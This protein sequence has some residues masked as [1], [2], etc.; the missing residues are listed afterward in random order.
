[1]R[2]TWRTAFGPAAIAAVNDFFEANKNDFPTNETRQVFAK[3]VVENLAFL[4]SNTESDEPSASP[5]FPLKR[6]VFGM[7]TIIHRNTKAYSEASSLLT[8]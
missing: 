8:R 5:T 4:Y 3:E 1:V 7:M 6:F 2:D